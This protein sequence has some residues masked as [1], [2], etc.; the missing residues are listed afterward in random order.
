MFG[1]ADGGSAG[2][3]FGSKLGQGALGGFGA[4]AG[5]MAASFG[6]KV[7]EHC[8]RRPTDVVIIIVIIVIV[9]FHVGQCRI[10]ENGHG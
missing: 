8:A 1:K 6:A 4:K 7:R 2:L 3:G 5:D 9:V 10:R